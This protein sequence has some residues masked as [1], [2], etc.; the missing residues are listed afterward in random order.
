MNAVQSETWKGIC[1]IDC[2]TTGLLPYSQEIIELAIVPLTN[3]FMVND[4][5]PIFHTTVKPEHPETITDEA[6]SVNGKTREELETFPTRIETV[7]AF[8]KWFE[9]NVAKRQLKSIVPL[10][11]NFGGF[12]KPFIQAWLDPA[13][14]HGNAFSAFF[15]YHYHDSMIAA[16]YVNSRQNVKLP[17]S[18]PPFYS[19]SLANCCKRLQ[20]VNEQ[21]HSAIGDAIASAQVYRKLCEL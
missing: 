14:K 16:M 2:E 13:T 20:I 19:T 9:E 12:D 18:K 10:G 15:H 21:E 11:H 5:I 3:D 1:A 17:G 4:E 6:L 8:V 7:R